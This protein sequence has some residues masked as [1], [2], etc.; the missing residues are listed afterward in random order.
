MAV[1]GVC[2]LCVFV[3]AMAERP[4]QVWR[5]MC[6]GECVRCVC[7]VGVCDVCTACVCG[8]VWGYPKLV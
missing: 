3:F 8:R 1:R 5:V 6:V 7:S 4:V 2:V